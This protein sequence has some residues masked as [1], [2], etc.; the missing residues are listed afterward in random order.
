M[1]PNAA[2]LHRFYEAFAR[3]DAEAMAACYAPD[4]VFND[5]V[6]TDLRGPRAGGMWRM[7]TSRATDLALVFDGIE[8][9]DTHGKAHWVATY[10][11]TKTGRKVVN[12][13]HARFRFR[14]GLIVEHTDAFDFHRWSRQSLGPVGLLLGWTP[15]LQNKVRGEAMRSLDAYLAGR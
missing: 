4:V 1:H 6:F 2:L 14:D 15:F 11:F 12:D 8:A 5:S 13:I 3:K 7:L 9:D 10:T